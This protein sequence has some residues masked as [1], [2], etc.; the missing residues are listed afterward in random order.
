[1]DSG[2]WQVVAEEKA[3]KRLAFFS[4]D[5]NRRWKVMP[6]GDLTAALTFVVMTMKLIMEWDTLAKE[7]GVKKFAPK[8]IA[9][10]LLL[11]GR[12]SDQLLDYFRTVLYVLKHHRTTL[13][14]TIFKWF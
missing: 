4:L 7:R 14:L 2:Y 11:D 13:K 6:M 8:I 5:E 12:T 3:L 9:H 1:M 10:D